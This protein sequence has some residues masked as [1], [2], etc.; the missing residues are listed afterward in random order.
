MNRLTRIV[1]LLL[2]ALWLPATLHCDLEAAGVAPASVVC[3]D[4][5]APDSHGTDNC[6]LVENGTFKASSTLLKVSAP[7]LLACRLC[8]LAALLPPP[9]FVPL[10]SPERTDSPPELVRVWHFD[11]RAALP[12]RAPTRLG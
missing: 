4:E 1:A 8:C 5:H 3:Q 12:S 7:A 2:L 10:V 11:H 6:A 9:V